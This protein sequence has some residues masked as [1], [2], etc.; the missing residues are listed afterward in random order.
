MAMSVPPD[1]VL[2]ELGNGYANTTIGGVEYRV[3]TFSVGGRRS[4]WR[5]AGRD[6]APDQRTALAG[7]ADLRR[8]DHRNRGRRLA[9]PLIAIDPFRLLAQQARAISAQSNPDEVQVRGVREAVEIA[10][11]VE[12]MLARIGSEAGPHQGRAGV[13][14][15]LRRGGLP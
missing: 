7:A 13:C 10:E 9:D 8:R 15:G 6:P 3:R 1:V 5:A 14:A 2:P 12:G 11:A 4:R